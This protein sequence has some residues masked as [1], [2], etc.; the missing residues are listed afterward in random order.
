MVVAARTFKKSRWSVFKLSIRLAEFIATGLLFLGCTE[1]RAGHIIKLASGKEVTIV[2]INTIH[3][4]SDRPA[5]TLRYETAT[6]LGSSEDLR[7]EVCELWGYYRQEVERVG[8][9]TAIITAVE[10]APS[11]FFTHAK[12]QSILLKR[13]IDGGWEIDGTKPCG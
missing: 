9:T 8:E 2:G 13:D 11:G 12:Q 5:W 6:E 3:F 10:K 4:A 7:R 1:R